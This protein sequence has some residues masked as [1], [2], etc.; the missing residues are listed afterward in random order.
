L[1]RH[2]PLSLR[3]TLVTVRFLFAI[4]GLHSVA[5]YR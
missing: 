4:T 5:I 2:N 3:H 1:A